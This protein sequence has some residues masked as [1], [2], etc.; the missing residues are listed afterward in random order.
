MKITKDIKSVRDRVG[1]NLLHGE[2]IAEIAKAHGIA[3]CALDYTTYVNDGGY[4][5]S[6]AAYA[7]ARNKYH[8]RPSP[9]N[10]LELSI[11]K[12][13]MRGSLIDQG[14][15]DIFLRDF[16]EATQLTPKIVIPKIN[17][18]SFK[19]RVVRRAVHS[20]ISDLHL[21]V[22]IKPPETLKA[23]G[24]VEQSRTLAELAR[25]ICNYKVDHRSET[26][27]VSHLIG[28]II[29][30]D[31]HPLHQN[32]IPQQIAEA[33]YLLTKFYGQ[34]VQAYPF[35]DVWCLSGNHDRI[36]ALEPHRAISQKWK[37]SYSTGIYLMLRD[38]F[39]SVKNIK[40][41]IPLAS[42]IDIEILGNRYFSTHGDTTLSVGNPHDTLS[43]RKIL[44]KIRGI[45][46]GFVH[47]G[48]KPCQVFM[49]GHVHSSG[50]HCL[51]NGID[52]IT[53]G[54]VVPADKFTTH[55][56]GQPW[57]PQ[58]Q[59]IFESVPDMAVGDIR[60]IYLENAFLDK[61]LDKIIPPW[62]DLE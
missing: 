48:K 13:D 3:P 4:P 12:K 26:T 10:E 35:V 38:A 23:F 28:D 43:L 36:V 7:V 19:R 32:P 22:R 15:R 50:Y 18:S 52:L 29:D 40:F 61:S 41:H 31:I 47:V 9:A 30:G 27:L 57:T 46:E 34:M 17:W 60:Q 2:K 62:V 24:S 44:E 8:G 16:K 49:T 53:N 42:S 55:T 56:L 21:G 45:N 25:N 39:A 11:L 59:I 20:L 6:P 37:N 33:V 51:S 54:G 14:N 1:R 58:R 5:T